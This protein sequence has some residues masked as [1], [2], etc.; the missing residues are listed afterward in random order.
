MYSSVGT[1]LDISFAVSTFSWFLDQFVRKQSNESTA[2]YLVRRTGGSLLEEER[3]DLK[4]IQMQIGLH[5]NIGALF[6]DTCSSWMADFMELPQTLAGT[7]ST[8]EAEYNTWPLMHDAAIWFGNFIS[9]FFTPFIIPT[10]IAATATC[11]H[12][13]KHVN[14]CYHFVRYVKGPH[15]VDTFTKAVCRTVPCCLHVSF[16]LSILWSGL[17]YYSMIAELGLHTVTSE[18]YG[19]HRTNT[20]QPSTVRTVW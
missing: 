20:V 14:M 11:F 3:K 12:A 1:W 5:R 13:Q 2:I 19:R 8:T 18:G 7:L 17:L 6:Q 10:T 9:K 4:D 15:T 16:L